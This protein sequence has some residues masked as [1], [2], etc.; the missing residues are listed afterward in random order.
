MSAPH[1][2][3]LRAKSRIDWSKVTYIRR[4]VL[5]PGRT[6]KFAP[7]PLS[8]AERYGEPYHGIDPKGTE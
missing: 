2:K 5:G 6:A 7:W 8:I 1:D 4:D 3:I